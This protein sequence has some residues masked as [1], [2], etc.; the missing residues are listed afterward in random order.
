MV[1]NRTMKDFRISAPEL[2]PG[3]IVVMDNLPA[4]KISGVRE[5]VDKVGARLLFLPSYSP[6][7]NLDGLLRTQSPAQKGSGQN[8]RPTLVGRRHVHSGQRRSGR[9]HRPP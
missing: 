9:Q 2:R 8:R 7:L 6:D 4:H 3:D 5:A 1:Q